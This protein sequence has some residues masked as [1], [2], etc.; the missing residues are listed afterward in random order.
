MFTNIQ[1]SSITDLSNKFCSAPNHIYVFVSPLK[2]L[3]KHCCE[4]S[5]LGAPY[6]EHCT[7]P[8]TQ[9]NILVKLYILQLVLGICL[10]L[11]LNGFCCIIADVCLHYY[12]D[13]EA[14]W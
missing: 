6:L 3:Y 10:F 14:C 2:N 4:H 1:Q 9:S 5:Y 13:K 12:L 8:D 11:S 7:C